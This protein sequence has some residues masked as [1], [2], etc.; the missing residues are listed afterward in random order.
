[1]A[2]VRAGRP[3]STVA[4]ELGIGA[5][6][7]GAWVRQERVDRG[8]V[9]ATYAA[10]NP[11]PARGHYRRRRDHGVRHAAALRHLFNKMLGQLYHC[12]QTRQT[13]DP[14][15]AFGQPCAAPPEP[16]AA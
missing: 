6:C 1:M 11:G 10:I 5:A 4:Y 2:L 9:W 15:K 14:I 12:L 13:F 3:A 7:V 16:A 8:W